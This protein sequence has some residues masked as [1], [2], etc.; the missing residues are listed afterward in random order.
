MVAAAVYFYGFATR[1]ISDGKVSI[2]GHEF[3]VDVADTIATRAQGLSGRE[4]LREN[5][6]ML[7]VFGGVSPRRFWMKDMLISIDIIWV[8]EDE[9]VGFDK[10][11]NPE[12]G[13][14]LQNLT[15]YKSP[16]PVNTVLEVS[17]GTVDKLGISVGDS[18]SIRL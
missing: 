15:S 3:K 17:A 2:N 6:G 10:N 12:P 1:D 13:V 5:E 4:E 7:F 8:N 11:V 16:I 18:V 9:V 14:A